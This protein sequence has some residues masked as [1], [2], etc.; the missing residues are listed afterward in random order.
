[1]VSD[2][3]VTLMRCINWLQ[4]ILLAIMGGDDLQSMHQK[5]AFLYQEYG[6]NYVLSGLGAI[7]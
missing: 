6:W 4:D 3:G 1:M 7:K 5:R 2:I